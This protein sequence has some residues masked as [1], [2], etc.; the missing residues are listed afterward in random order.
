MPDDLLLFYYSGHGIY[1]DG[2]LYLATSETDPYIPSK[3]GFNFDELR[4]LMNDSISTS[5]VAILDCYSSGTANLSKGHE[6]DAAGLTQSNIEG[7]SYQGEGSSTIQAL[8]FLSQ[9]MVKEFTLSHR[10]EGSNIRTNFG[11]PTIYTHI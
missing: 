6:F 5:I 1:D 11:L 7:T 10:H 3:R 8:I 2:D 4:R 9:T